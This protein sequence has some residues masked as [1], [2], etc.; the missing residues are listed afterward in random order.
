MGR[1]IELLIYVLDNAN[2][3]IELDEESKF[4]SYTEVPDY[5]YGRKYKLID[6]SLQSSLLM[7]NFQRKLDKTFDYAETN[8]KVK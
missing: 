5:I 4:N 7:E 8:Q 2:R 6:T 3:G 1:Q